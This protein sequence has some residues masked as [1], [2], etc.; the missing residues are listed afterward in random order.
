MEMLALSEPYHGAHDV[1]LDIAGG[2]DARS[3]VRRRRQRIGVG[4]L[5]RPECIE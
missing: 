2:Y 3:P 4:D 5:E 1:D